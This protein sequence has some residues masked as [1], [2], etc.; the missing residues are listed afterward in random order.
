MASNA[1]IQVQNGLTHTHSGIAGNVLTGKI[2]VKN[3]GKKE[4][5]ILLYKQDLSLSC[6]GS[7]EYSNVGNHLRSSASWIQ[8]S[9][10]E[11]VI[12]VNEEYDIIYTITIPDSADISGTYWNIIMVEGVDPIKEEAD[13][14]VKVSSRVRY[15]VQMIVD[16]GTFQSPQMAFENFA[17][18]KNQAG[19]QTIHVQL[20]NKGNYASKTRLTLEVY[21]AKG[22][23]LKVIESQSK[24]LY[25]Q[26][27]N[28]FELELKDLPIGKYEGIIVADNGKDLFGANITISIQ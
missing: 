14:G 21:D 27:C 2:R 7:L 19:N 6:N 13:K 18:K 1:G 23:K 11:K 28:D 16:V 22:E 20:A 8:T 10:D 24:R 17:Y 12:G 4:E 15:A 25:P 5:R 26:K 3:I 9:V